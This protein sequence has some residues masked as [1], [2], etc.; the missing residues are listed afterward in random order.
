MSLLEMGKP[1]ISVIVPVLNG[2]SIIKECIASLV[3]QD[4]PKNRY[5]I[6]I[7]DNGSTDNTPKIL[8]RFKKNI[9]IFMEPERGPSYARNLGIKHAQGKILL[10]IDADCIASKDWIKNIILAFKKRNIKI[11]G[12][13]VKAV[14]IDSILQ[15]YSNY[16]C[17]TQEDYFKVKTPFFTT[18]NAAIRK[19]DIFSAGLFNPKLMTCEDLELCTR[20]IKKR[21]ELHYQQDAIVYHHYPKSLLFFLKKNYNKGKFVG[22]LIKKVKR[23]LFVKRF[24]YLGI[25]KKY[26]F[27]F[28]LIKILHDISFRSGFFVGYFLKRL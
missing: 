21:D 12:G 14:Q 10:F 27:A 13:P 17:H 16:F 28:V 24:S 2:N 1:D 9:R 15:K 5:E 22:L 19:K 23:P 8:K 11:V 6:I 20:L 25:F 7:V 4:F 3:K 18:A 26:G